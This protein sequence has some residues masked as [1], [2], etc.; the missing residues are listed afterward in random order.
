M[1]KRLW[2]SLIATLVAWPV[3]A[4]TVQCSGAPI[5][6][7]GAS[8]G[9]ISR[10]CA[11]ATR[12]EALLK[13]CGLPALDGPIEILIVDDAGPDCIA[14]YHCGE[15][16]IEILA[17]QEIERQWDPLGAFG[18]LPIEAYFHSVLVHELSH[19]IYDRV[20]C[21]FETCIATGEYLA[22][23]L[24]VLSLEP[25]ERL[26]FEARSAIERPISE[27]ELNAFLL[28]VAPNRFAQKAWAHL[29]QQ[30]DACA[31]LGQLARGEVYFDQDEP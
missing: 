25:Q 21:R 29:M 1:R 7:T 8:P 27:E 6:V 13:R 14:V 4:E 17:P 19:A 5:E 22:Y 15:D 20:P 16:R 11:T 31:F 30:D 2:V 9:L 18:F 26:D 12:T 10:T 24:Q 28:Y 3:G 23:A